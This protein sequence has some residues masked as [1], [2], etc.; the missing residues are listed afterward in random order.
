MDFITIMD[1]KSMCATL[2]PVWT[3]LGYVIFGIKVVVP[4]ILIIS[5]MITMA[6]AV[7][8]KKE[9]KIKD[10]QNLLIKQVIAAV[11]VFLVVTV[12][13]VVVGLVADKSWEQCAKCALHPFSDGCEITKTPIMGE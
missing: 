9:D 3:L 13:S 6:K 10:A 11:L 12:V 4:V 7:M 5:G 8:E 1:A 2:S